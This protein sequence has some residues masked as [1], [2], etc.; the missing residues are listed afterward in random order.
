M[1]P[2]LAVFV[3]AAV[4]QWLLP[5]SGIWQHERVI[6]RGTIVRI[7]CGAPDPYDPLRG[8]YLAVRPVESRV[9]KPEGMAEGITDRD[10]VPVWAT[11]VAGKDGLS[12]IESLSL[13]PVAGP[14][15][16]RLVAK[17]PHWGGSP[18]RETVFVE[19]PFDRFYLNERLAPDADKLV[20]DWLRDGKKTVA[21][22][23]L[24]DGRAVLTDI[25]FDGVSI[26]ELVK[27]QV[28]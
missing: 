17:W 9:P 19:W 13:E 4:A 18:R 10:A 12:R 15:V 21:E 1:R 16:I 7:E 6:A 5:L 23:S 27:Q 24:L 26:R 8:R 22:V 28:K 25:L 14:T 2:A 3:V 11:L 20:A